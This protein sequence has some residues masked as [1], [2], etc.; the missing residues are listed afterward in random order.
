MALQAKIWEVW[1][2]FARLQRFLEALKTHLSFTMTWKIDVWAGVYLS[3]LYRSD[4][5]K[6]R[7]KAAEISSKNEINEIPIWFIYMIW[8]ETVVTL[9]CITSS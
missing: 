4:S 2:F 5:Q 3:E 9:V 7:Q 6:F 1:N 8:L